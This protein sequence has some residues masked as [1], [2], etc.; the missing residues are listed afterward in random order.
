MNDG[1]TQV[2]AFV[3]RKIRE[4]SGGNNESATRAMLA[5]LR[6]GIGKSPGSMPELWGVTLDGLPEPLLGRGD[7]PT[8]GE[9]AVHTALT[10]FALHQQGNDLNQCVSKEGVALGAAVRRLVNDEDDE[11]RI[12]RRFDAAATADSLEEFCYHLRGLIQLLKTE[13]I[14]LDYPTLAMDLYRFQF[15]DVR[16]SVRLRWG[17][18]FYR[19]N[20]EKN[21]EIKNDN[22]GK[23]NDNNE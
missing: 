6:R 15:P 23:D 5:R 21:R 13:D 11:A 22:M 3:G 17:Q 10:L 12:K 9:W 20:K 14:P 18:D 19:L 4:L 16:D 2:G 8:P 1:A 7:R